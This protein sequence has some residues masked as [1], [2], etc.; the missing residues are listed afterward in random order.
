MHLVVDGLL[1][2]IRCDLTGTELK[3]TFSYYSVQGRCVRVAG[4]K[5]TPDQALGL[6]IEICEEAYKDLLDKVR[7]HTSRSAP[8]PKE[9]KCD[10]SGAIMSGDFVYWHLVFDRVEVDSD[11]ADENGDIPLEIVSGIMDLNISDEECS[12]LSGKVAWNRKA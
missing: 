3:D 6:D 5:V 9:V 11:K 12:N 4:G 7:V 10:L 1:R 8:S 2:G